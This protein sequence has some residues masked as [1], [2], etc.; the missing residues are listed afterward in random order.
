MNRRGVLRNATG[1]L[2]ATMLSLVV[3]AGIITHSGPRRFGEPNALSIGSTTVTFNGSGFGAKSTVEP[4]YWDTFDEYADGT[5]DTST[6]LFTVTFD[7]PNV[8]PA[9]R[10]TVESNRSFSGAKSLRMTYPTGPYSGDGVFPKTGLT[11]VPGVESIYINAQVYWERIA[12]SGTAVMIFK[13]ARAGSGTN[14]TVDPVDYY[15]AQPQFHESLQPNISGVVPDENA[16][17]AYVNNGS[18]VADNNIS[19]SPSSG[20]WSLRRY[21]YRMHT[22]AGFFRTYAAQDGGA[23]GLNAN[24]SGAT[25]DSGDVI[26]WVITPFDGLD[27]YG[28]TNAYRMYIDDL[29]IDSTPHEVWLTSANTWAASLRRAQLKPTAWADNQVIAERNDGLFGSGD[30]VHGFIVDGSGTRHYVGSST[31]P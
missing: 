1:F 28:T 16:D 17:V 15:R 22:S 25:A 12:G 30:T 31:I 27:Q 19:V 4:L 9:D 26:N 21:Q 6:G 8:P 11:I 7:T 14:F 5:V 18:G 10:P 20:V 2:V 23:E 3:S 24:L 29:W 13:W